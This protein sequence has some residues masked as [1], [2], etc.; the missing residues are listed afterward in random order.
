VKAF[1]RFGVSALL[2]ALALAAPALA[3]DD[4]TPVGTPGGPTLVPVPLEAPLAP[5]AVP[6]IMPTPEPT[7]APTPEP[8]APS[9]DSGFDA[10]APVVGIIALA[11]LGVGF[12]AGSR[13]RAVAQRRAASSAPSATAPPRR[14]AAPQRVERRRPIAIAAD[15]SLPSSGRAIVHSELQPDGYVELE[16]CLRRVR[17]AAPGEPPA[18]GASVRVEQRGNRLVAHGGRSR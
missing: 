18:V 3:A 15:P 11:A 12:L 4:P 6:E 16:G 10:P 2:I 14:T 7:P 1:L 17:W 13:R 5:P 8:P 9:A